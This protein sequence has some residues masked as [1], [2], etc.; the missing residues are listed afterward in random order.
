MVT[1]AASD[2]CTHKCLTNSLD[3]APAYWSKFYVSWRMFELWPKIHSYLQQNESVCVVHPA[4]Y[5]H[6]HTVPAL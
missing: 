2:I 1:S 5:M 3:G 4:G 6:T